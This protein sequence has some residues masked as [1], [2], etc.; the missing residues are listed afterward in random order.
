MLAYSKRIKIILILLLA[1]A[2]S[3]AQIYQQENLFGKTVNRILPLYNLGFP[4]DTIAPPTAYKIYPH[5]SIKN[6]IPYIWSTAQGKWIAWPG[7]GDSAGVLSFNGRVGAVSP[8][9]GDYSGFYYPLSTNPAGY[10]TSASLANYYTK[11]QMGNIFSGATLMPGYNKLYWDSAYLWG[12][13]ANLYPLIQT[14][15]DS[16]YQLRQDIAAGGLS[17]GDT[18]DMLAPYLLSSVAAATYVPLSRT[19][20]GGYGINTIGNLSANRTISIDSATLSLKYLRLSDTAAMKLQRDTDTLTFDATKTDL[21]NGLAGITGSY[22][23]TAGTSTLTSNITVNGGNAYNAYFDNLTQFGFR[24][25]DGVG[26]LGELS[27]TGGEVYLNV[28]GSTSYAGLSFFRTDVGQPAVMHLWSSA[29]GSLNAANASELEIRDDSISLK[30]KNTTGRIYLTNI[31]T[32]AGSYDIL[33]KNSSTNAVEKITLASLSN[34]DSLFG[35]QDINMGEDRIAHFHDTRGFELDSAN[36]FLVSR[37]GEQR[38]Y[39]NSLG[40]SMYSPDNTQY[41]VTQNDSSFVVADALNMVWKNDSALIN[42]K[43]SY[44]TNL[45]STF[46]DYS[47]VDKAWVD[48]L[49]A[50]FSSVSNLS[51]DG[52]NHEVDISGGGTSAVIPL[53]DAS[54][55]GLLSTTSQIIA[56]NKTFTGTLLQLTGSLSDMGASFF[57]FREYVTTM[58]TPG[59]GTGKLY[60]KNTDKKIYFKNDDGTEYDLTATGGGGGGSGTVTDF[61]A[62]DLS[63]LFTT[64]EATT[65]TTPALTFSLSNAAAHTFFGN[66]TGST[67]APAYVSIT[68]ADLPDLSS[69]YQPLDAD[70]TYLA[71]F[72]PTANVKTI[73]NAAD[74][75]AI[76]TALGLVI[77]TNV[78]AWDADLD[79]LATFTPTANVKS[80]LNAADYAA[81]K[82]LLAYT[83]AGIS[84]FIE[85]TQD[86]IGAEINA[87]LQYVDGTP[88]LAIGDRDYGPITVSGSGL[89]WTIDN[90]A[91][92]NAM[93]AGSIA[94]SKLNLASSLVIADF[95]ATGTPSSTT[96]LR[97]DNTWATIAGGGDV[98]K[99][100]TPVNDQIGVWT[101]D[102]TLEGTPRFV[103][104]SNANV[105]ISPISGGLIVDNYASGGSTSIV[106]GLINS[107]RTD[108]TMYLQYSVPAG[109]VDLLQDKTIFEGGHITTIEIA[110]PSTPPSG[111]GRIFIN[112]SGGLSWV[113]DGGNVFTAGGG[114]GDMV[115][116]SIQS[117][118][119]LKTFDK[120]KFAMKGTSTGVTTLS[121][122][123][124]SGTSYTATLQAATGTIAYLADITGTNSGT[125]TGDQT[126]IVGIS[127]TTAQF[128]T[129]LS[130]NDF[131][132]LAGS[133]TLSGKT[134]TAPKIAS[135]GFIADANGNELIIF[136]TTA[137][138]VNE[139]TFA[140]GATGVNPKWTASGETNVGIDWQVK[141]TGV[142]RFLSTASGPTDA[143]WFEDTDNG[144]NYASIIAPATLGSDVVI[145]LPN[146]S[147]TLP[148]FG[149]Q[150]TF[151]GPTAARTITLPDANFT[152][153]RTDA[154]QTFTGSN[155]FN[156]LVFNN[157]PSGAG[158][159]SAATASTLVS[160]DANA[161]ITANN[162]L[163]GYTTTATAA[164]TTTLTV[165]SSYLQ[166]FT[167]TTTQTVTLPVTSTL[168]L[169]HQFV[170]V[171][172]S[173]GA[174]T[175][176]SSGGNAVQVVK[177]GTAVT[178]TVI[179]T[180][181]TT[182]ASWSASYS[183]NGTQ[184]AAISMS[185]PTAS[186]TI[187]LFYTPVALTVT[188][189]QEVL[190]GSS[191][192]V[193]YTIN[194]GSS[195]TSAT[196]TIVASH[197]ATSTS[198]ASATINV[199]S[200]PAGS[201]IWLVTTAT[202]GTVNNFHFTISYIQ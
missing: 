150:I 201:Y 64:S 166:Y 22:I 189:V 142:Y 39:M 181:G 58:G 42:K 52:T 94:Y 98:T 65:T 19:L 38:I 160:R 129:A 156:A 199:A 102:G 11:V 33:T 7:S 114:S 18:A 87:S 100:G 162:W 196:S 43:I 141:G 185:A 14:F 187:D 193:T 202:S 157:L 188:N 25:D 198:G 174:V 121:T 93:L 51:W 48:S 13:H 134:L 182:A 152:A 76:R 53:A 195:P 74:Y 173:T 95:S 113:D 32:S 164:G 86:A 106:D 12:D 77:G 97:G 101:G 191:P 84:D 80:I 119:G 163:G 81:I 172:N 147:S 31:P 47:H 144:S 192:S 55:N 9:L 115:L 138:A 194:Y 197:A 190:R 112:T 103:I 70:L 44:T 66:N 96:Y 161:N 183:P 140:N 68:A 155:T 4:N 69:V 17:A 167:G 126:S 145:T 128:N 56:G 122:A 49:L 40:T 10:L 89:T 130:D 82:T 117:V 79:Y 184:K 111:Y 137:S 1:W 135:G 149:Q 16:I 50:G 23:K 110:T 136:T 5:G 72:T 3:S 107:T 125:N 169:G 6:D 24:V 154:G 148:I 71:G 26:G 2:A 54:N 175:V 34:T 109:K 131:A 91:V 67:A 186:E 133:E 139:L 200:I 123:N 37:N 168:T 170:I 30:P 132:T 20:T 180:S 21:I 165:S 92:T 159:A 60:V 63:P 8:I 28:T 104:N 153:A 105:T 62:G 15:Y 75:V 118:T 124:A 158:V 176:N 36:Y 83:S 46:T 41:I 35:K 85:A 127:G 99:V 171:N 120:D 108:N 59:T 146:A 177:A 73:L 61:S 116:A 143:R 29:S 45:H 78:Q 151:S 57:T 27:H 179:L 178:V 88:L 90:S